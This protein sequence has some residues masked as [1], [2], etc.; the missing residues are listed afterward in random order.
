MSLLLQIG[1][2]YANDYS[3]GVRGTDDVRVGPMRLVATGT[4]SPSAVKQA[5]LLSFGLAAVSWVAWM[6]GCCG[7]RSGPYGP[8]RWLPHCLPNRTLDGQAELL[9]QLQHA[10]VARV[11]EVVEEPTLAVGR[12]GDAGPRLQVPQIG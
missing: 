7:P 10:L 9:G 12:L 2:N 4:A 3:D 1:V 11:A 6:D 5:A 8:G